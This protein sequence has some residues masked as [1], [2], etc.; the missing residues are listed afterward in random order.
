MVL[1]VDTFTMTEEE[2]R[3]AHSAARAAAAS[4]RPAAVPAPV[5]APAPPRAPTPAPPRNVHPIE[6]DEDMSEPQVAIVGEH[7]E[8]T[9][10]P[11]H[12]V[13][14]EGQHWSQHSAYADLDPRILE[15]IDYQRH[16]AQIHAAT[17]VQLQ[18][19]KI[20]FATPPQAYRGQHTPV[21]TPSLVGT[22]PYAL[23]PT[24]SRSSSSGDASLPPTPEFKPA[25]K[26]NAGG[27]SQWATSGN[28]K[29][30]EFREPDVL[31]ISPILR[32]GFNL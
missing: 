8:Y 18:Q 9:Q 15:Q 6:E 16:P 21:E 30:I 12:G 3:H 13:N 31:H 7:G 11:I 25:D 10:V 4:V 14:Y 1:A 24:T 29:P 5:S 32:P 2:L 19:P 26:A 22:D 20:R 28:K 23:A 17:P 27:M